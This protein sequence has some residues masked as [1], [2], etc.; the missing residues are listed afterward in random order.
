MN[1]ASDPQLELWGVEDRLPQLAQALRCKVKL[2]VRA[3]QA[4][5]T[6]RLPQTV[7]A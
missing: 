4:T 5:A 7:A 6:S 1:A 2:K 3:A